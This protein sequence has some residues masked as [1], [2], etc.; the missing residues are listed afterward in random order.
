MAGERADYET[1]L[2]DVS[3]LIRKVR[4]PLSM[5]VGLEKALYIRPVK[6]A[7]HRVEMKTYMI[8][9]DGAIWIQENAFLGKLPHRITSGFI[10]ASVVNGAYHQN[11]FNFECF[12]LICMTLVVNGRQQ[13]GKA[14]T[15]VFEGDDVDSV[16]KY[17]SIH[18]WDDKSFKDED[19]GVSYVDFPRSNTIFVFN[20]TPDLSDE[21]YFNL[22]RY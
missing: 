16:R 15:P 18:R 1:R 11:P 10:R 3:L 9:P 20:L 8:A 4:I 21:P 19:V 2:H 22:A 17:C 13:P 7:T 12:N 14:F 6:Y 5:K